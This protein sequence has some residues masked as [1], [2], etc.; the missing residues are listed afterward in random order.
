MGSTS[1]NV[2]LT[3]ILVVVAGIFG[4]IQATITRAGTIYAAQMVAKQRKTE[5]ELT[6]LAGLQDALVEAANT[7]SVLALNLPDVPKDLKQP[8]QPDWTGGRRELVEPLLAAFA[9]VKFLVPTVKDHDVR[10][11]ADDAVDAIEALLVTDL[12]PVL[13][14]WRTTAENRTIE[15]AVRAIAAARRSLLDQYPPGDRRAFD[16]V[17]Y[18]LGRVVHPSTH[19]TPD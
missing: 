15:I 13:E 16:A 5:L 12:E 17:R 8:R 2:S 4:L 10:A 11:R 3:V 14:V 7:A 19:V 6:A 1:S 9:K 18:R